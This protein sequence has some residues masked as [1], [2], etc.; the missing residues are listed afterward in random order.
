MVHVG[1]LGPEPVLGDKQNLKKADFHLSSGMWVDKH[2]SQLEE[3][4]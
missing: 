4:G 3:T 2:E 1:Q